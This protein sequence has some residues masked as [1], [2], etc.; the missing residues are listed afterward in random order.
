[1]STFLAAGWVN[2]KRVV[3]VTGPRSIDPRRKFSCLRRPFCAGAA[4]QRCSAVFGYTES[5]SNNFQL[6]LLIHMLLQHAKKDLRAR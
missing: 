5:A 6:F 2:E 1:M 3:S 4:W